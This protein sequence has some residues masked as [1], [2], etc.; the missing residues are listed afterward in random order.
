MSGANSVPLTS[1]SNWP[2]KMK[3]EEEGT[4][5][6]VDEDVELEEVAVPGPSTGTGEETETG[7]G[8]AQFF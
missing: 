1:T 4:V 6:L 8:K 5:P 3:S 2:A 7:Q